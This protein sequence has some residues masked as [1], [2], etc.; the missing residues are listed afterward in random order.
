MFADDSSEHL[1]TRLKFLLCK[2]YT[3]IIIIVIVTT[4]ITG[5]II[6][7]TIIT[8][9]LLLLIAMVIYTEPVSCSYNWNAHPLITT[10]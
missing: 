7:A 5:F 1:Q 4:I 3:T 8:L 9:L 10:V 2:V 6:I